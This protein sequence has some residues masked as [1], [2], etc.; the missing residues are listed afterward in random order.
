MAMGQDDEIGALERVLEAC[1]VLRIAG[2]ERIDQYALAGNVEMKGRMAEPGQLQRQFSP[3]RR[4][5]RL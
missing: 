5:A 1:G 4:L 3:A 2:P